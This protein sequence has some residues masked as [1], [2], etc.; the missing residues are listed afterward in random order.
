MNMI[1]TP[2]YLSVFLFTFLITLVVLIWRIRS[3]DKRLKATESFIRGLI[4]HSKSV[5]L[6][7]DEALYETWLKRY[8][9]L[10][11]SPKKMA[12]MR[13]LIEVGVLDKDGNAK[14]S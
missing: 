14:A 7:K 5:P 6:P 10:E 4:A 12:Y 2:E 3:M 11:D 9:E 8:K 13:R 1:I